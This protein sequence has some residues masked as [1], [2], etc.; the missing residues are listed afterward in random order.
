MKKLSLLFVLC[1]ASMLAFAQTDTPADSGGGGMQ[2]QIGASPHTA[3]N[4]SAVNP[5]TAAGNDSAVDQLTAAGND[6]ASENE[7]PPSDS[8]T[9]SPS[10]ASLG[11]Q[12][13]MYLTFAPFVLKNMTSDPIIVTNVSAGPPGSPYSAYWWSLCQAEQLQPNTDCPIWVGFDPSQLGP[14]SSTLT[15]TY[16][17]V[18]NYGMQAPSSVTASL[19]ANVISDVTLTATFDPPPHHFPCNVYV[20]PTD[21]E[22]CTMILVNQQPVPVRISQVSVP[23][24][25]QLLSSST[26]PLP[27]M[28]PATLA[29]GSCTYVIKYTGN[30][31]FEEGTFKVFTGA[32]DGSVPTLNVQSCRHYCT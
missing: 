26:C 25:Y 24:D 14:S 7:P 15:V 31:D 29:P 9:L 1:T 30:D 19:S 18:N 20:G 16:R 8:V 11:N 21:G 27:T 32:P 5:L 10:S 12:P 3:G 6:S 28:L 2:Q 22:S 4:D 17:V 23:T 13:T